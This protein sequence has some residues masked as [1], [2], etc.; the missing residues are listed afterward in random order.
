MDWVINLLDTAAEV[1]LVHRREG[2]RAHELTVGQ[3]L[4]AADRGDVMVHVPFQ[5]K[6]VYGDG[7]VERVL[8]FNSEDEAHELEVEVDAIL[9][10]LGFKTA[11]GPLKQWGFEI[12]KGA[13]VVDQVMRTSLERVWACGDITTFNGKLKLIATGFAESAIAVAQAVHD[14]RPDVKIQPAYS[15]NTGVPGVVAGQP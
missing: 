11:L 5:I 3:V 1:R 4:E 2:F 15:T 8:L 6:E 14:I 7:G 9:L 13:I 12:E 10:Q